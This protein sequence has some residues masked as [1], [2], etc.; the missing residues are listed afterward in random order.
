MSP[1]VCHAFHVMVERYH[2]QEPN[3]KLIE[4]I[5][6]HKH[7][8]H[9]TRVMIENESL[10]DPQQPNAV[11][12]NNI[13]LNARLKIIGGLTMLA[14]LIVLA[15]YVHVLIA[16]HNKMILIDGGVFTMGDTFGDGQANDKPLQ[17][18]NVQSF[19]LSKYEVTIGEWNKV[20]G[21]KPNPFRLISDEEPPV[22]D[23]FPMNVSWFDALIYCNKRSMKE[24]L[25]PFYTVGYDID[26]DNW[27]SQLPEYVMGVDAGSGRSTSRW[28]SKLDEY[29][30]YF[31]PNSDGYRL[32][33]EAEWEFAARGGIHSKGYEYSGS[34]NL[35][36]VSELSNI[37]FGYQPVGKKKANEL[38]LYDMSGNLMEWCWDVYDSTYCTVDLVEAKKKGT[39]K[40]DFDRVLRGGAHCYPEKTHRVCYRQKGGY[41]DSLPFC[42]FRV[43]RNKM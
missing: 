32:P 22:G 26:P 29:R 31:N 30:I 21:K 12:G 9:R 2:N 10:I 15:Y 41:T 5:K 28:R 42:G 39:A 24:G 16:R 33:T 17:K 36:D 18:Q 38:G 3:T 20:V 40:Y 23:H 43:A 19:Y 34:N 4:F 1:W 37:L 13:R 11:T 35:Q 14:I 25:T 27:P 8:K 7:D 6:S